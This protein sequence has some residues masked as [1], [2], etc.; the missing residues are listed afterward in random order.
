MRSPGLPWKVDVPTPRDPMHLR[1]RALV[2]LSLAL[3]I[4]AATAPAQIAGAQ[5][6]TPALDSLKL[7]IRHLIDSSHAPSV[8]VAVSRGGKI[9]WE[10]G[11][12]YAD[13]ASHTRATATTLYSM[14]S[15]S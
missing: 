6:T 10:E 12:G 8:A 4:A 5:A 11:F 15:I 1:L 14:A 9:I 2:A 3:A 13:I 7:R